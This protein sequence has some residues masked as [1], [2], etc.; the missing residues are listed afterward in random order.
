MDALETAEAA[1][2][3]ETQEEIG[4]ER[5]R[6]DVWGTL[7]MVYTYDRHFSVMPIIANCGKL[8]VAEL[9]A[10][11]QQD[12]VD[13]LFTKSIAELCDEKHHD[14][15]RLLMY[16]FPCFVFDD[17]PKIWGLTAF[18]LHYSLNLLVPDAYKN[19]TVSLPNWFLSK[20]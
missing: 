1:A 4:L 17:A 8:D 6:I 18:I 10:N 19:P 5:D 12:E 20:L 16:R 11:R 14:A 15:F 3:R 2:L 13:F 9:H 7:P